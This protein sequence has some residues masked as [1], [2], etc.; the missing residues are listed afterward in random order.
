MPLS[1]PTTVDA[2]LNATSPAMAATSALSPGLTTALRATALALLC[3]GCWYGLTCLQLYLLAPATYWGEVTRVAW[4][5][6]PSQTAAAL[7]LRALRPA[8]RLTP[9]G[10]A[11]NR[12]LAAAPAPADTVGAYA[13]LFVLALFLRPVYARLERRQGRLALASATL[14]AA[15]FG[16]WLAAAYEQATY[17][18][19]HPQAPPTAD[20]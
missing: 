16:L 4:D 13:L 8:A 17:I 11:V 6:V 5:V 9:L 3:V 14:G 10:Q 7:T 2:L 12:V 1:F 19:T 18:S 20:L 15:F